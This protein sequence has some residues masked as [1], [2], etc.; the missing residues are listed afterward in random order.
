MIPLQRFLGDRERRLVGLDRF[1]QD[2][3]PSSW[4]GR[5]A[6]EA[7]ETY[8]P[9]EEDAL[10]REL[11]RLG[12]A[13]QV[14]FAHAEA[15]GRL[16]R[17]L[18]E[19]PPRHL[20][21]PAEDL[22]YVAAVYR[23]AVTAEALRDDVRRLGLDQVLDASLPV[24]EPLL[25]RLDPGGR[26]QAAFFL[27]DDFSTRLTDVRNRL[28]RLTAERERLCRARERDIAADLDIAF[29]PDD[30]LAVDRSDTER[31]ARIS[32]HPALRLVSADEHQMTFRVEPTKELAALER[33]WKELCAAEAREEA[34]ILE[35]LAGE[36]RALGT[37][38]Q[39]LEVWLVRLDVLLAKVELAFRH[40]CI[41]PDVASDDHS[42]LVVEH[43]VQPFVAARAEAGGYGYCPLTLTL[44]GRVHVLTGSN[45][46]GKSHVLR[47]ICFLQ[48]LA[49]LGF[50][51]PA[52]R[53][54]TQ[55]FQ[56]IYISV[57]ETESPEHGLSTFGGEMCFVAE[58]LR[59]RHQRS[60]YLFDEIAAGTSIEAATTLNFGI[61]DQLRDSP[62]VV[63]VATHI[64]AV[65]EYPDATRFVTGGLVRRRVD[66]YR[67]AF[68]DGAPSSSDILH[69]IDFHVY[70]EGEH[71]SAVDDA[72]LVARLFGVDEDVV[73]RGR[74]RSATTHR[75][76]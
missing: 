34:R 75:D 38:L 61:L 69:C 1:L 68:L 52:R 49:Q 7:L 66:R 74:A 62:S 64:E 31:V 48:T 42:A 19:L 29:V 3:Q 5:V 70:P 76:S 24:L 57:P 43:G 40:E 67:R 2:L 14:R 22:P 17:R 54:V 20:D 65:R 21:A 71:V 4:L 12:R 55:P 28:Q 27:A 18:E 33:E 39:R 15:V 45:M 30:G 58:A 59:H 72:L 8:G 10:R 37:S 51:V 9:G 23:A 25:N 44:D 47:T 41:V 63:L 35:N 13:M 11:D 6:V 60:L 16:R 50:A 46:S 36:L 32:E 73:S 56:G 26:R 53:F